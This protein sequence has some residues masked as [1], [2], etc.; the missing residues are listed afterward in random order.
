MEPVQVDGLEQLR[1]LI[2][3]ELGPTD[4]L[5]ITQADID[6]FAE[7]SRDDQ[8]IHVDQERAARESPYGTTVAHGNLTLSLIDYF[9]PQLIKNSGVKMGINYGFDRVRFPPAVP[10]GCG[11]EVALRTIGVAMD[12]PGGPSSNV[13]Y[14]LVLR[15]GGSWKVW[16][17]VSGRS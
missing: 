7:V 2:G 17:S 16:G 14:L 1:E 12:A 5:E 6:K 15:S 9:R 8:W 3:R 13:T 11:A 4:W 10:A